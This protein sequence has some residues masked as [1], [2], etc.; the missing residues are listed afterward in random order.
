MNGKNVLFSLITFSI[1]GVNGLAQGDSTRTLSDVTIEAVR[2]T[3]FSSGIKTTSMDSTALLHFKNRPLAELLSS[4]SPINIKSYGQGSL[5]TTSFRGGSASQTAI[6]WNGFN[7]NS[8][9]NGQLD[10]SLIPVNFS[11]NIT[12]QYGGVGALWGSGAIG[13]AIHLGTLPN[14]NSGL[15]L[16]YGL[17]G[18]SYHSVNQNIALS[19][20]NSKVSTSIA[21]INSYSANDFEFYNLDKSE[22]LVNKSA[23][24]RSIGASSNSHFLISKNQQLSL[25][26]WIQDNNRNIPPTMLEQNNYASQKDQSQRYSAD[27]KIG[28][29]KFITHVRSAY[30]FETLHYIDSLSSTDAHSSSHVFVAEVETKWKISDHHTVGFGVNNNYTTANTSGYNWNPER[31]SN[32]VFA[33]YQFENSSK[34][35]SASASIRQELIATQFSPFTYATGTVYQFSKTLSVKAN[36]SRLYRLPTFNDL[37][38]T[39]GG[40]RLLLPEDGFTEEL[41]VTYNFVHKNKK[42]ELREEVTYFN[43]NINNW[44]IWLPLNNYWAPQNLLSVWSRGCETQSKMAYTF[45]KIRF[46]LLMMTNYVLSSNEKAKSENDNS[47]GKQLI[48]VPIYSAN[49]RFSIGYKYFSLAYR[50]Q[51]TGYRYTATDHSQ[52]LE[53]YQ[54]GSVRIDFRKDSKS[55]DLSAFLSVDNLWNKSYQ[56]MPYRPMPMRNYQLG[57]TIKYKSKIN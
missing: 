55:Y 49:G 1:M 50:H 12:I 10:L 2:I 56:I 28:V 27:W 15:T 33:A 32:S 16:Q 24:T 19:F 38:W 9:T 4:E 14:Y 53:P 6:V 22:K 39:P 36:I 37:Y 20:G 11:N 35:W 57:I 3:H 17:F 41:G 13:G 47:I 8:I 18:G 44:I 54:I 51:Y 23:S 52:F 34:R 46:Q 42:F 26:I 40:N 48:Y 31:N 43:R 21:Y 7:I 25:A 29:G 5:A 30:F 45:R